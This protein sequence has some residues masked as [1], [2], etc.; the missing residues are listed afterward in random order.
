MASTIN[1][2]LMKPELLVAMRLTL[3]PLSFGRLWINYEGCLYDLESV[4]RKLQDEEATMNVEEKA[5]VFAE[6]E[7]HKEYLKL[8]R[9]VL[10]EKGW[11]RIR[12]PP[13]ERLLHC[14]HCKG[15]VSHWDR[16]DTICDEC[17]IEMYRTEY[18][19]WQ[20]E[21]RRWR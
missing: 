16:H 4:K 13:A 3:V 1:G 10:T 20:D 9:E 14:I 15:R 12:T 11:D 5:E 17:R 2:S 8:Y 6:I 19:N 18:E 21:E 7:R